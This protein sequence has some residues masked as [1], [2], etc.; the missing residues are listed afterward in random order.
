MEEKQLEKET[1]VESEDSAT[2]YD[3]HPCIVIDIF[4]GLRDQ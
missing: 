3:G 2:R 4:S 1:A